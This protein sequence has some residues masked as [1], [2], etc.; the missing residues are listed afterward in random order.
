MSQQDMKN[1]LSNSVASLP[2]SQ[3]RPT[4][5]TTITDRAPQVD[6]ALMERSLIELCLPAQLL[7]L[8]AVS[9][10]A[11]G[12]EFRADM[13][14]RLSVAAAAPL[15]AVASQPAWVSRIAQQVDTVSMRLA[16]ALAPDDPKHGLYTVAMFTIR[17]VDERLLHDPQNMGVLIAMLLMDDIKLEGGV[18][19][20]T[21]REHILKFDAERLLSAARKE[22]FYKDVK[23]IAANGA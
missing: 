8:M 14:E 1:T 2:T 16:N 7:Y 6:P 19:G 4:V 13:K 21:F 22:G 23:L 10:K 11:Q 9:V 15:S 12:Y 3:G 18:E 5:A 20:Y 17:L